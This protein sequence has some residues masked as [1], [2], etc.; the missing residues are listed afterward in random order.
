MTY[1]DDRLPS[2]VNIGEQVAPGVTKYDPPVEDFMVY[3]IEGLPKSAAGARSPLDLPHASICIC[4]SG[5]F[6][7]EFRTA[8]S[9][10][11]ELRRG[12]SFFVRA[13]SLLHILRGEEGSKL[14]V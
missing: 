2:L 10:V 8:S 12:E 4:T 9:Q 6:S 13:G 1:R 3:E 14:Y 5:S 7:V 11:E